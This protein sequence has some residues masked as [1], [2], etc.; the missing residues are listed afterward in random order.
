MNAIS[1]VR[2]KGIFLAVLLAVLVGSFVVAG[3]DRATADVN[4]PACTVNGLD[5][6]LAPSANLTVVGD[7]ITYIA[8]LDNVG[9][10][11]CND[12]DVD[13]VLTLPDGST[14][15]LLTDASIPE[16]D[17]IT[18]PG[19]VECVTAGPYSYTVAEADVTGARSGC[20]PGAPA[21]EP[22]SFVTAFAEF[23][24]TVHINPGADI[25]GSATGC[26]SAPAQVIS[27]STDVDASV[28]LD[29]IVA[30][31]TVTLTITETNDGDAPLTDPFVDLQP[32]GLTLDETSAEFTGGD[33]GNGILDP[34]E[35]WTWEVTDT[36]A[37]DTTYIAIGHGTA[38]TGED[39]TW[40]E[41]VGAP[42]D[43]VLCDQDERVE[44][45][46]DVTNPSTDVDAS[47]D[48]DVIVVGD[49]VQLTITESN[50]GDVDLTNPFVDL[51][52]LGLTLD[53][54]SADFSGDDGDGVLEVGETWQW[55]VTDSPAVDTTYIAIGH[56][57]APT[58]DDV[59]WC[60]DVGAPPDGVLC[61][62]DER[63]EVSVDVTN[64]STDVDAS[65]DLDVIVVGDEVQLTITESNDGDVDLTNPFVDLQPL[66]LT[67]TDSSPEF[68]G[69][70][71]GD[72]ILNP[73][74][75]W[76]W[77]VL[78]T[79]A[80]DT[81]YVA[82]GHGTA[83]TGEDVTFCENGG[84][85]Q[86]CDPDERAEIFVDV[87]NPSISIVKTAGDA[88]D[89]EVLEI[90][91]GDLVTFHYLVC[92]T[93][94]VDLI[95]GVVTDDNGTPGDDTDD[96]TVTVPGTLAPAAEPGD[97]ITVDSL[98]IE[99]PT[100]PECGAVRENIGTVVAVS[101]PGGE[102]VTASD[103]AQLC[104]PPTGNEGCTP[105]Y[106]KQEQHF[107][108]WTAPYTPDT[109][110]EDVFADPNNLIPDDTTLLDALEFGGGPGAEGAARILARAAVASLLNAASP[111]VDFTMSVADVIADV[112][113]ALASG[114]RQTMLDLAGDLDADNNLGCP[115]N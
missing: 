114:N 31:D 105:G 79:P 88:L 16:G 113:A 8:V 107:D 32:L 71:D 2:T 100:P 74:E 68:I 55:L 85:D 29:V 44:V 63:A 49:E 15:T 41:D 20:P 96:F 28:D 56:G 57:T 111:D 81:T 14:V 50:D 115:L 67:L 108:N 76:T 5:I 109:L 103:P 48:L 24:G 38:P 92:N 39:V 59:T 54:T 60:E 23:T 17:T 30:G 93:G 89:G 6:S 101:D 27:P 62:Q 106:W 102:E 19:D 112:N 26:K 52:P 80:A 64:P 83:P 91:P 18:C 69:G 104:T 65:V 42:P 98:P 11:N 33:D 47:V 77:E 9:I 12:T 72:G 86:I 13:S 36:P 10:G 21:A 82:I 40:C 78:D 45:S 3:S 22:P 46:V 70:D 7:T 110:F 35:S 94:D 75:T 4:P 51:Q 25:P 99:I 95:N 66:G 43:G 87:I 97:C 90:M 73:G 53:E 61:D 84:V 34:A 1:K 37:V 58:G